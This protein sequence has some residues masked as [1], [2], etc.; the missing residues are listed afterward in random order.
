[1]EFDY[2]YNRDGERFSY[3]MLPRVLLTDDTF[4]QISSDSKILYAGN[5]R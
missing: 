4:K 1:M 2:F 3:Y 5:D